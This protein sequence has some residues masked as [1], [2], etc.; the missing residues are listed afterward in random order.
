MGPVLRSEARD[1]AHGVRKVSAAFGSSVTVDVEER[2]V[3]WLELI[4]T[5]NGRHDLTAARSNAE[6]CDLMLADAFALSQRIPAGLRLVDVGSGAGA[7]G[8]PL[9]L[10]RPNLK[11]TLVEPQAKRASFLRTC[12]GATGRLD[13]DIV[14]ARVEALDPGGWDVAMSRATLAPPEWLAVGATL[15]LPGGSVWVLVAR[16]EPPEIPGATMA[17]EIAY[18]LPHLG[19]ARRA[20]RYVTIA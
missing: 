9:A 1:L 13:V 15:V 11:V 10:L 14:R 17:E 7:P 3:I 18:A 12:V 19:H 20:V 4:I 6:L 5:W 2:L 8:F 16:D